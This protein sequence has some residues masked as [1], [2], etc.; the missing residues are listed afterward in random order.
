[1]TDIDK[2]IDEIKDAMLPYE[3]WEW[4]IGE[5]SPNYAVFAVMRKYYA[6]SGIVRCNSTLG[7]LYDRHRSY[8]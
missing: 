6:M 3:S 4:L 2:A 1:M 7:I 5:N 8:P